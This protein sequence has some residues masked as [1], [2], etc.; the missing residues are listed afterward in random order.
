MS[1]I[2]GFVDFSR[3]AEGPV[4]AD[5]RVLLRR[6]TDALRHRGPEAGGGWHS[7]RAALGHRLHAAALPRSAAR[8]EG[9]DG[10]ADVRPFSAVFTPTPSAAVFD[11]RLLETA[12]LREELTRHSH[13]LAN[14]TDAELVLRAHLEWGEAGAARLVGDFA[15]ALWDGRRGQLVL[16]RDRLGV[17]PLYWAEVPGGV[18]FGSEPKALLAHPGF[19]AEVDPEGLADLFIVAGKRPGDAV[20]R[21]LH[22]VRPG[23][24]VCFARGETHHRRYWQLTAQP[25]T[26]SPAETVERVRDLLD[27][28][29]AARSRADVPLGALLSGGIDSSAITAFAAA[30]RRRRRAGKLGTYSVDFAGGERDFAADALHVDRDAPYVRAVAGHLATAHT[31][32]LLEPPALAAELGATLRAR[33]MPG[34]GDLDASLLLLFREVRRHVAV[35][36]SGEG[37]DDIFGGFPWFRAEAERPSG[38]FPWSAGVTDRNAVLAPELRQKL[39]LHA[40]LESRYREAL[41]EV[42]YLGAESRPERRA[43]EVTYLQLTRFLPFLLDRKDRMSMASGL[44]VRLPFTDHRLVEYVWNVPWSLRRTGGVE[45]S[46]LRDAVSGLLPELV[47]RRPKS[48]FPFGQSPEYLDAVRAGVLRL[49]DD[50][51]SAPALA[52]LDADALR[53]LASPD[54]PWTNGTFTPPPWLPRALLLNRWL[55]EYNVRIVL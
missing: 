44:E 30:D 41:S 4:A 34:V 27:A 12:H 29:V 47:V 35:A 36:L 20:L 33:D 24:T 9:V 51:P 38:S 19:T 54:G 6:M 48:G 22:E 10:Q 15:F 5:D 46:L 21:H 23:W 39:D 25:H 49:V 16:G 37:A 43:R 3:P 18:V 45:K 26:D 1:G 8:L 14:P 32:V 50:E 11:G 17:T 31:E 52:L 7:P 40:A 53:R 42:P 13:R 55:T 2:A 28:A